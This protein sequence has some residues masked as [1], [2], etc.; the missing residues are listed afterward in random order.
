MSYTAPQRRQ[1]AEG[2]ASWHPTP[3]QHKGMS[4]QH[5]LLDVHNKEGNMLRPPYNITPGYLS[6]ARE[7]WDWHKPAQNGAGGVKPFKVLPAG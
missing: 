3:R 5:P 1:P 6:N 7:A 2:P 4:S